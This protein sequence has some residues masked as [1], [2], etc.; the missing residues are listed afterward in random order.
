MS[1]TKISEIGEFG[2]IDKISSIVSETQQQ[3]PALSCGIGDDCLIYLKDSDT[4]EVCTTDLLIE[5][6]HFD[7]LTTPFEHL[8]GKSLSVN[9]SDI[10]AMNAKPLYAVVSLAIPET[11][12]VEM[13]EAFY[14]GMKNAALQYGVAIAGGDTSASRSGLAISITVVGEVSIPKLAKRSTAKPGDFICIS[15]EL[16]GSMAGLKVLMRE[17][18][19]MLDHLNSEGSEGEFQ[20]QLNEYRDAVSRHLLP[21]ARVDI[22]KKL[23]E[24]GVVPTAMIDV[25]DGLGSE[26]QHICKQSKTGAV[27]FENKIPVMSHAREVADDFKEDVIS[28]ALFGGEDYELL[29]TV[30]PKDLAKIEEKDDM[31]I[32][33]QI[34]T[35]DYG[36]KLTDIFGSEI[37]LGKLTGFQHFIPHN[38]EEGE[39]PEEE[40]IWGEEL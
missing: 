34:K 19:L 9:V 18:Q 13:I 4:Y 10:C 15:G 32:I 3:T 2:L 11:I 21:K 7:L 27:L 6:V 23:D 29:F 33:G 28:Y 25:S 39:T 36:I 30:A 31:T 38:E 37:D 8:G 26:T 24:L 20:T 16:G 1:F 40:D 5:N 35:E 14:T 12:S 17:K 22:V